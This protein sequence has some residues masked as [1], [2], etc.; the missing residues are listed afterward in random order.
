MEQAK[1]SGPMIENPR[2]GEQIVFE[3]QSPALLV[4]H[5]TWTRPGRRAA[6]HLHPEMEERYEILEG[7]AAFQIGDTETTAAPG[8]TVVVPPGTPHLAWNPTEQ[9]VR[10]RITMRPALRWAEF[11][12]RLFAGEDGAALLREF[13][14]EIR[15]A[16]RN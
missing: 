9:P 14:R 11:V 1:G 6:A 15:L 2:T 16:P 12:A 8:D 5:S 10:L 4:M 3:H 7:R 13:R